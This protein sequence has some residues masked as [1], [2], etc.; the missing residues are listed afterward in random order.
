MVI[1]PYTFEMIE[2]AQERANKM[3][4]L[5][6]SITKGIGNLAGFL[7]EEAFCAYT[8]ASIVVDHHLYDYDVML[9]DERIEIKT[10]RRTVPPQIYY[11]VSVANTST[12]QRPDKY[13]F[14]SLEFSKVF[15]KTNGQRVYKE[16]K[17]V[18]LLGSKDAKE[19]FKEAVKVSKGDVDKSNNF[20]AR[21]DM[22]NLPVSRLK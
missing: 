1:I 7:A 2:R 19:Y 12:H 11:D 22:W 14:I 16:L 20:T 21:E 4:A 9:G 17:N 3:G 13:I 18:W 10:K 8:G 5:K 15:D 6:N